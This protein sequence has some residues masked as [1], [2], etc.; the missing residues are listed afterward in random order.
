MKKPSNFACFVLAMVLLLSCT[1]KALAQF[2]PPQP[3]FHAEGAFASTSSCS[4]ASG[5]G[6]PGTT[7]TCLTIYVARGEQ[8]EQHGEQHEQH[9]QQQQATFLFYN[10]FSFNPTLI[11]GGVFNSYSGYGTIPDSAFQVSG[12][13]ASLNVDTSTVPGFT[14]LYC[15]PSVCPGNTGT[16]G[17]PVSATWVKTTPVA[18]RTIK[19]SDETQWPGVKFDFTGRKI[20]DEAVVNNVSVLAETSSDP[21]SA[22]LGELGTEHAFITVK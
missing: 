2:T 12:N 20:L 8:H 11:P 13:T 17:G 9:E 18:Q 10:L 7:Y 19:G 5:G 6:S 15:N 22:V 4:S 14:N 16:G 21:S 1:G 3:T